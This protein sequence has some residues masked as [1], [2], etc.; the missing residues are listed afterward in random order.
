MRVRKGS[1]QFSVDN[2]P[3]GIQPE[4]V[5]AAFPE[6]SGVVL[7]GQR[8]RQPVSSPLSLFVGQTVSI[9]T[10]NPANGEEIVRPA[11]LLRSEPRPLVEFD[12]R[13]EVAG[14]W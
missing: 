12:G 11:K 2:L 4:T 13:V 1:G 14:T 5:V 3:H 6:E 9:V 8:F 10:L 7:K